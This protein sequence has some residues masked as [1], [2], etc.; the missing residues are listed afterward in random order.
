ML[1]QLEPS[2]CFTV[3]SLAQELIRRMFGGCFNFPSDLIWNNQVPTKVAGFLWQVAHGNISTI[4][5][6]MRRGLQ[7]PNRCAMCE[8]DNESI[9]HLFWS[10]S[11]AS[12]VWS[13]FSSRLSLLGPFPRG[14]KEFVRAWKGL[15]CCGL[16]RP[17]VKVLIHAIVWAVWGE[18]NN[19]VFRD[20]RATWSVVASQVAH[21]VG[22]WC[23]VGGSMSRGDVASWNLLLRQ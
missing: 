13:F 16:F 17:G 7:I 19:R 15:N 18:R 2:G 21:Q 4:D 9:H 3:R 5:N 10:C 8:N 11:F 23:E 1:W 14:V 22:R 12:Q 6:L 20:K